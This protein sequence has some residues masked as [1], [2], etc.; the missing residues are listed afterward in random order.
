MHLKYKFFKHYIMKFLFVYAVCFALVAVPESKSYEDSFDEIIV[1]SDLR[2][3]NIST[4]ATSMEIIN[5]EVIERR[6]A[7]HIDTLLNT[8][9][10][11][12]FA[13]GASRGRFVQ[14]RG[15]GERSQFVEPINP[16]VGVLLDGI[17]I[18]GTNGAALTLD[19]DRIEILR[20]PQGTING[21]NALAGLINLKSNRPEAIKSGKLKIG[22]GNYE[23][24]TID[25]SYSIPISETSKFRIAMGRTL[26]N[27]FMSNDFLDRDNTNNINESA[28]RSMFDW[29]PTD[30][31]TMES[32][33]LRL[34]I[35]NGYDAFSL[36]N[37]RR[38]LSNNPGHDRLKMN[39]LSFKTKYSEVNY[40][41]ISIV[42]GYN[43]DSEYGYDE[44]WAFP[45]ICLGQACEG[46]E[47][48]S[49]DNYIRS[50]TNLVIDTR[51]LSKKTF[52][53]L[54]SSFKWV[55]GVYLRDQEE[56]LS[57]EY[58]YLQN[59]FTSDFNTKNLAVYGQID[60]NL[61]DHISVIGGV[62]L[63]RRKANYSD[64]DVFA[65]D[66]AENLWGGKLAVNYAISD[67]ITSYMVLSRG[68]KAG[69][70]NNNLSLALENRDFDTEYM[71]NLE[72]GLS[73]TWYESRLR[74]RVSAFYQWR[75]DVQL[76]QSLVL[77]RDDS[78]SVEFIDYIGNSAE[79]VN[80]GLE[81]NLSLDLNDRFE[82]FGSVGLLETEFRV[83]TSD[84]L[85]FREQAHAP[86]Y[87]FMIG[88]NFIVSSDI[89]LSFD[90]EGK[91]K[92]Y[93]SSNHNEESES[94]TLINLSFNYQ[95]NE[96]RYSL[97]G[98]NLANDK[99]IIRGFGG[100]GNDPRKY[101]VT[102]PYYQYGAPRTFG[103]T[104]QFD[105]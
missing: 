9:A 93:L 46:W 56:V 75:R 80:Y 23:A 79:G 11:V 35:D 7:Q 8:V 78:N 84:L 34:D 100:F 76:K 64:S 6:K 13:S 99:T 72:T 102:E 54:N 60:S 89:Y 22:F 21:A 40:D 43:S 53:I 87:Q 41:L 86:S 30:N 81:V 88:G 96:I 63:E 67:S 37:T 47:Y 44:D 26:N 101:Y 32:T 48:S 42:S 90:V 15:I 31:L 94:Y 74:G 105:F 25:G 55:L 66:V 71:W 16:S 45:D 57:R 4:T 10:N 85:N 20:G 36:D 69:G 82:L 77:P 27:G 19:L 58:T 92:F 1:I 61:N 33:F 5:S 50:K 24:R 97:W 14:I 49:T 73:G 28:I 38:T 83:P 51:L 70:I 91:D 104:A 62:R 39:G 2:E 52:S 3:K 95:P 59:A 17:D 103:V 68:Y 65:H 12:N 98:K 18:S 29:Q